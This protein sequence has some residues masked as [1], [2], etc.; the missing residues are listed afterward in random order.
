MLV[1]RSTSAI[2]IVRERQYQR[3]CPVRDLLTECVR[4]QLEL[5]LL[6]HNDR[7]GSA[8]AY[9]DYRR[10]AHET[11]L[12]NENLVAGLYHR[13]HGKVESLG[14]AH[15]HDNLAVRVVFRMNEVH[16]VLG[17]F[18][19]EQHKSGICSI[20]RSALFKHA[21]GFFSGSPGGLE[22]RLADG[23]GDDSLHLLSDIEEFAYA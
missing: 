18:L 7:H 22:I 11:R 8:A 16:Q 4:T 17:Y 3:L 15:S 12:R 21:D 5:V 6:R 2:R 20:C 14:A 23:Q 13:A 10:I 1:S 9:R 19:A